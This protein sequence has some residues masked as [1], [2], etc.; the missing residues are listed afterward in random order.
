MFLVILEL[1]REKSFVWQQEKAL[2]DTNSIQSLKHKT[3][4]IVIWNNKMSH[5]GGEA[6]KFQKSVT[7]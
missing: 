2:K 1:K 6:E 5:E 7:Y 3:L 4:K